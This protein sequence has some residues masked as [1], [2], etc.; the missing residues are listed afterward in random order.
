[1]FDNFMLIGLNT[2][3]TKYGGAGY[4]DMLLSKMSTDSVAVTSAKKDEIIS[5]IRFIIIVY[6]IIYIS[7][8]ITD[9]I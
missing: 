1:M 6:F 3:L 5:I 8:L 9:D 4:G 7:F 2:V